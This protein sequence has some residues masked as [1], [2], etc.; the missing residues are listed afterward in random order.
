M[1]GVFRVDKGVVL[2]VD[3]VY[4]GVVL[5]VAGYIWG[6][7]WEWLEYIWGGGAGGGLSME[8]VRMSLGFGSSC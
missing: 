1:L 6:L 8:R 5:G 2:G 7:C 4:I 3:G